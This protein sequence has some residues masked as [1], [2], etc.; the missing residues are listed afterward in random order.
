[1]L[2]AKAPTGTPTMLYAHCCSKLIRRLCTALGS[3]AQNCAR[4]MAPCCGHVG[5]D[6]AECGER[7][8][9]GREAGAHRGRRVPR[10]PY[11][12]GRSP[13]PTACRVYSVCGTTAAHIGERARALFVHAMHATRRS[14]R[15][16]N[17]RLLSEHTVA[18]STATTTRHL[19]PGDSAGQLARDGSLP[20][21]LS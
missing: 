8:R 17:K 20:T 19:R 7:R 6:L 18:L 14:L 13:F 15:K 2:G 9:K 3:V 16:G 12:G 4:R 10:A 1:M 21:R 11:Q 5:R